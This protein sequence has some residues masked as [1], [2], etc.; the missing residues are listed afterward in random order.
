MLNHPLL[1]SLSGG[2][3]R[4]IGASN[5]VVTEVL[6]QPDLI[7]VLFNG[8]ESS[9]PVIRMR[10]ADVIEKVSAMHPELL[11]PFKN[12]I[13]QRLTKV[14]QQEVRWHVAAILPRLPLTKAEVNSVVNVLLS[15]TNDRSS[16][17]KTMSMQALADIAMQHQHLRPSIKQHIEELTQTGTPGMQA[18]GKKLLKALTKESQS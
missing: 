12:T 14:Q 16:I 1:K 11:L 7:S 5:Q 13:L 9:D 17:V 4:S 8:V 6:A 10:C 15:F 2:D 18:R 3:L